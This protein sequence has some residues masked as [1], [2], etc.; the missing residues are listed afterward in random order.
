M[1]VLNIDSYNIDFLILDSNDPKTFVLLDISKYLDIP[2]KPII[3]VT[4]P[5]FTGHIE[6]PYI[7]NTF[8]V[9][10]SDNLGL[11]EACEYNTLSDLP[12]GVYQLK[13]KV[14]PYDQLFN[15]KCYLKTTQLEL[16]FQYLLLSLDLSCNCIDEKKFKED[17]I[18]I[19]ILIQS[20]KAES[21]YCNIDKALAK[22]MAASKKI[23]KLTNL[24]NCE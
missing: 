3:E 13:I 23:D 15:K 17:I 10:N 11:T 22:Y 19:S 8:T 7:P 1:P 14:C 6:I 24:L 9:F 18:D 16:Q 4:L 12:D 2:I 21:T 5:G 20:A